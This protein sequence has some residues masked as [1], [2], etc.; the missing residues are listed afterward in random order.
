[1]IGRT[2]SHY[3]IVSQLGV[4]G[5]GVVYEAED[6][7]LGRRV[8]LK[9]IP[10][11]LA[12][13]ANAVARLRAEA[14]TASSLNHPNICTIHDI[15]EHDGRPFIVMELL[16]GQSL[17]DRIGHRPLKVHEAV[18]AGIQVADALERAHARGIIHRDIKPA[19]LFIVDR[20]PV[21]VL[22]FGLAKLLPLEK[23]TDDSSATTMN[24]T[25]AG[26]TVGTVAYMSPEQVRGDTLDPRTDLFSLGAV[27][28]ECVTGRQPFTGKTSAVVFASILTQAPVA[29]LVLNPG[30]P[31]RLQDVINNCL[32][33]DRELRYQDAAGL[34]ADLK[35]VRRDL[36]SGA[37]SVAL[38]GTIVAQAGASAEV[39][40]PVNLVDAGGGL[41]DDGVT[42]E[43]QPAVRD[44]RQ[45]RGRSN[46]NKSAGADT[47]DKSA[48]AVI[49]ASL[50]L[51]AGASALGFMFLHK[52]PSV[53]PPMQTTPVAGTAP[54][55]VQDAVPAVSSP[56]AI[57]QAAESTGQPAA[58]PPERTSTPPQA[59]PR[60][61]ATRQPALPPSRS[62][63]P[64]SPPAEPSPPVPAPPAV[65]AP[66]PPSP[67]SPSASPAS[68]PP[69]SSS[70]SP[71]VSPSGTASLTPPAVSAPSIATPPAP[72]AADDE[73]AIR[74]LI[75]TYARAIETKDLA[76]FRTVKPNLSAEEQ[77]RLADGFRAVTSQQVAITIAG[78]ERRGSDAIVRVR[79][80][81]TIVAS[82]RQQTSNAQQTITVTQANGG[83]V[84]RDIGR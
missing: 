64:V 57:P 53:T 27:L 80:R 78:I 60:A 8:A 40:R 52:A 63:E 70:P 71:A 6:D 74:R 23:H 77:R 39:T 33:K 59:A 1:M 14:R 5:M 45:S 65:D 38:T 48:F 30:I 10:E 3:R 47:S 2:I 29:P 68:P 9:F 32:E 31:A 28:Y 46:A 79:R 76:L 43:T 82:G 24:L 37:T 44:S 58:T 25:T 67:S 73:G 69:A 12:H 54:T 17:R 26:M 7:R 20:G 84:I 22:D 21:K 51:A 36:E 15:G 66:P 16:H 61:P 13:D 81:D 34:R 11:E 50:T 19:N 42:R 49:A 72:S 62:A 35:R 56:A 18:D 55:A 41:Q 4:G 83:W 75:A